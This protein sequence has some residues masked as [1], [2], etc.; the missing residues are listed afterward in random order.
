MARHNP[1][2]PQW[3]RTLLESFSPGELQAGAYTGKPRK[4]RDGTISLVSQRSPG[5][6]IPASTW[7]KMQDGII[8]PGPKT[9]AKLSKFKEKYQYAQ[10][11]ASGAPI[12]EA[13]KLS[14]AD[15]E[16]AMKRAANYVTIAKRVAKGL[17]KVQ[18]KKID[19]TYILYH[20]M[21]GEYDIE[22]WDSYVTALEG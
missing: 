16:D 15:F 4:S 8:Q 13:K 18:K 6:R 14:R 5:T 17:S 7:K 2:T 3:A 21:H 10:L 19:Y 9:L 20:M 12:K 22:D 11:R 1:S